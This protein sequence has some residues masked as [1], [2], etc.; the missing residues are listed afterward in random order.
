M[1]EPR[2][3]AATARPYGLSRS[4]LVTWRRA[5]AADRTKSE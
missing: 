3:V 5:F 4:V 1:S 2:L